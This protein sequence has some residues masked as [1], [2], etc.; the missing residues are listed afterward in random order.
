MPPSPLN[1][2]RITK[3]LWTVGIMVTAGLIVALGIFVLVLRG[4]GDGSTSQPGGT[5]VYPGGSIPNT[6]QVPVTTGTQGTAGEEPTMVV[7]ARNGGIITVRDFINAPST[8][9]DKN[10]PGN[11]FLAGGVPPTENSPPYDILYNGSDQSFTI[12]L[13]QEPIGEARLNAQQYLMQ[14]LGI[15]ETA[16]CLLTYWVGVSYAVN[17]LYSSKNLGFSFCPGATVL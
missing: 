3:I 1:S 4:F 11:Y 6:S 17:P 7:S 8:M 9:E 13:S 16:M 12:G 5:T 10:N 15:D 14:A 2:N